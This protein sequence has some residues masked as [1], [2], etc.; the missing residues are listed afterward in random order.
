[1]AAWI[2]MTITRIMHVTR[3]NIICWIMRVVFGTRMK[4]HYIKVVNTEPH[5]TRKSQEAREKRINIF[6][7]SGFAGL[8]F[9]TTIIIIIKVEQVHFYNKKRKHL[10]S[11]CF[12]SAILSYPIRQ[13]KST[14]SKDKW[15]K[16]K[17]E[18]FNSLS[19]QKIINVILQRRIYGGE[20]GGPRDPGRQHIFSPN[21]SPQDQGNCFRC[22]PLPYFRDWIRANYNL[23]KD[24]KSKF[25]SFLEKPKFSTSK[26]GLKL[27]MSS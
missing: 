18:S 6:L 15:S 25:A 1:M 16:V 13:Q 10:P 5:S 23:R 19:R 3:K 12:C 8:I 27:N 7:N 11:S 20:V 21:G 17:K 24:Y 4:L 14:A 22:W 9:I 26:K 2:I